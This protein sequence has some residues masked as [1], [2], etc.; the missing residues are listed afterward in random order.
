MFVTIVLIL[1]TIILSAFF[2]GSEIAY[3]SANKL[4]IEV[5]KNKGSKRGQMLTNLYRDPK[6]FLSCLLYTSRCV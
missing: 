4:S 1:I 5:L 3:L 2:S 6:S